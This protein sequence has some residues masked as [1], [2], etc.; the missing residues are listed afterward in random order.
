MGFL[1]HRCDGVK[2]YSSNM[3]IS[4]A[5]KIH[6]AHTMWLLQVCF[7]YVHVLETISG[8]ITVLGD[9]VIKGYSYSLKSAAT[10]DWFAFYF[11]AH[12]WQILV[13]LLVFSGVLNS[14]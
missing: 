12:L 8:E 11:G 7:K 13:K 5:D 6:L 3:E 14:C 9:T 10:Y 4:N 2:S 1:K